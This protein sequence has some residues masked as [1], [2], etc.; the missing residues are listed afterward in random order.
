MRLA[1]RYYGVVYG[2]KKGLDVVQDMS[3][4]LLQKLTEGASILGLFIMGALVQNGRA[5]TFRLCFQPFK[6]KTVPSK[7]PQCKAFSTA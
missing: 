6:N 3:G 5:L 1:A 7:L 4:G 2:Y